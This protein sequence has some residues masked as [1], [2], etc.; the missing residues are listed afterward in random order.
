MINAMGRGWTFTAIAG[1]LLVT[2]P[3]VMAL[4]VWGEGWREEKRVR[5]EKEE[6]GREARLAEDLRAVS[7]DEEKVPNK[8]SEVEARGKEKETQ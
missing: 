7:R 1:L 8:P 6:E 5:L 3:I 4:W 2:S